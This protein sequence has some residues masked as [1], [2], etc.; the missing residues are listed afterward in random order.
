MMNTNKDF[1]A[2]D[3]MRQVRNIIS[4]DIQDL[5]FKQIKEY[6]AHKKQGVRVIPNLENKHS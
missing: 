3:F 6:L 4:H 1:K 5:N 2:V